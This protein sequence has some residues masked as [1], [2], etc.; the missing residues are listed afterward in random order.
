MRPRDLSQNRES[1]GKTL[2]L[3]RSAPTLIYNENTAA[4]LMKACKLQTSPNMELVPFRPENLIFVMPKPFS[5]K[6][7]NGIE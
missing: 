4:F 3:G 1:Y 2:R 6:R 7:F 5:Q